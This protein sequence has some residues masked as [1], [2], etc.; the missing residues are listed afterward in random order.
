MSSQRER[1]KNIRKIFHN[2]AGDGNYFS[3]K[4]KR[5][6]FTNEDYRIIWPTLTSS[7]QNILTTSINFPLS[8]SSLF[9]ASCGF[10]SVIEL[11]RECVFSMR[12]TYDRI[13]LTRSY[14]ISLLT[15]IWVGGWIHMRCSTFAIYIFGILATRRK[16]FHHRSPL[17][18]LTR[19]L[20][21]SHST[22]PSN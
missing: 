17:R 21:P 6:R 2:T 19:M 7:T 18:T 20:D 16:T 4:W 15:T 9:E 11:S 14:V 8:H 5:Y 13:T 3:Q 1:R 12:I 22:W 10:R